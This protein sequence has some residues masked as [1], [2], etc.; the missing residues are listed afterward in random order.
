MKWTV[1]KDGFALVEGVLTPDEV[2]RLVEMLGPVSGA[3]R[4]GMLGIAEIGKLAL[5]ARL[6]DLV[7]PHMG[8]EVKAVRGIYFDKTPQANRSQL[9]V[10][11]SCSTTISL[12]NMEQPPTPPGTQGDL[13]MYDFQT[14]PVRHPE[15]YSA[16]PTLADGVV[17]RVHHLMPAGSSCP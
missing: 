13:Q 9:H 17:I 2:D 3:G 10:S 11:S 7:R 6:V 1:E 4:R 15:L 8:R 16:D 14:G 5:S 12:P